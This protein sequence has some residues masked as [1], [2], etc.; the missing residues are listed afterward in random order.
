VTIPQRETPEA[1]P[2]LQTARLVMRGHRVEDLDD[3]AALWADA[4][5]IQYIGGKP[6][7]RE[8]V[9][10]KVLR[11][12]GHWSAL[13]FGEWVVTERASGRF[14]GEVGFGDF[15]RAMQPS[16]EGYAEAGWVLAP[17]AH[18]NGFATEAL[19]AALAWYGAHAP[20]ARTVCLIDPDNVRSMRVADK[21]GYKELT[22]TTYKGE[23]TILLERW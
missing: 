15:K 12:I 20:G 22:R 10:T 4:D 19:R 11:Y 21:C 7:S 9:W 18:G 8:E 16:I 6:F 23:P 13:G 3:C 2:T 1:I 14:V 17:W 5:V